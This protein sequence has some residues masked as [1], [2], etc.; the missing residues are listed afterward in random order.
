DRLNDA[1]ARMAGVAAPQAGGAVQDLAAFDV[2]VVHALGRGQQAWRAPELAVGGER[3]PEGVHR[4]GLAGEG[5]GVVA[6]AQA[7]VGSSGQAA[8]GAGP[9]DKFNA[10]PSLS[11]KIDRGGV[12]CKVSATRRRLRQQ[13]R[14]TRMDIG[15]RLQ[16]VRTARGLSQRELARRVGVT[17]STISLIEQNK[18]SPS[19]SSLKKVL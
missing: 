14:P 16:R 7:P 8:T 13:S 4:R 11:Q 15:A 9:F 3:H 18:V 2:S 1:R 6:H 12:P 19:V 10:G 17:N 5:R